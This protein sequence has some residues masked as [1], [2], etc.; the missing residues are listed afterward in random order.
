[1]QAVG[2]NTNSEVKMGT[3]T[4]PIFSGQAVPLNRS[5]QAVPHSNDRPYGLA[6]INYYFYQENFNTRFSSLLLMANSIILMVLRAWTGVTKSSSPP[7]N[8]L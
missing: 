1:M 3:A 5:G 2:G 6:P 8:V 4:S 7:I